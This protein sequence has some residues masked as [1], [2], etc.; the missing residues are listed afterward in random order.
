MIITGIMRII[1]S[2]WAF[3]YHGT[4]VDKLHGALLGHSLTTYAVV[5]LIV[6]VISVVAGYMV[7]RPG[8]L[9]AEISRRGGIAVAGFNA[10]LA[11]TWMP[12]YPVWSLVYIAIGIV[13]IYALVVHF[14]EPVTTD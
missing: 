6:G 4:V 10:L 3:S 13:V 2:I 12:Y 9:S 5:W 1:D 7:M 8:S 11:M 14:D